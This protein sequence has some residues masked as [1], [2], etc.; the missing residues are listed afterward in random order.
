MRVTTERLKARAEQ[1]RKQGIKVRPVLDSNTGHIQ[2]T[3]ESPAKDPTGKDA[4]E[5]PIQEHIRLAS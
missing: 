3:P 4:E 5:K 2:K 1:L